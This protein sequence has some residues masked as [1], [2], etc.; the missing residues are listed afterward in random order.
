MKS[1]SLRLCLYVAA[2]HLSQS[3]R[4]SLVSLKSKDRDE[5]ENHLA[6]GEMIDSVCLLCLF[7]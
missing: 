7:Y 4:R 5:R 3:R 2:F 1:L 6:R